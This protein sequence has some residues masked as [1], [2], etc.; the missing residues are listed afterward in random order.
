M[1]VEAGHNTGI[2]G[3]V[4]TRYLRSG[5]EQPKHCLKDIEEIQSL[6]NPNFESN[7]AKIPALRQKKQKILDKT[8]EK[9]K[10]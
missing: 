2:N 6:R 5:P 4:E 3:V 9:K 7:R 1:V 10:K 8:E